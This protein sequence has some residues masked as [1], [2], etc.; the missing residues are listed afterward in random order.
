MCIPRVRTGN[1]HF[2]KRSL[3]SLTRQ[4]RPLIYSQVSLVSKVR[5]RLSMVPNSLP[6]SCNHLLVFYS[7]M[8]PA[9]GMLKTLLDFLTKN[10]GTIGMALQDS[11]LLGLRYSII[12]CLNL[13]EFEPSR[14]IN[15]IDYL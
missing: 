8:Y 7:V 5:S 6:T 1:F 10:N 15:V 4:C 12:I 9:I 13:K 3:F 2:L 11:Y 14:V